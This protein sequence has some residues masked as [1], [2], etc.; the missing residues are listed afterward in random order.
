MEGDTELGLVVKNMLD[1]A[2]LTGFAVWLGRLEALMG[3][4]RRRLPFFR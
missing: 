1:A 2:D 4:M 3:A